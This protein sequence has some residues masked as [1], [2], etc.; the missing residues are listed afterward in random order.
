MKGISQDKAYSV[1]EI[2]TVVKEILE[3][4]LN[5]IWI[6]GEISNYSSPASGHIYFTLKDE[7]NQ[8]KTAF[9]GGRKKSFDLDLKDGKK[10]AVFGRLS[11]YGKRSE[12]QIIAEEIQVIGVGELLVE[13]EKLKKKL[14]SEGLFDEGKKVSIPEFPEKI[15]IITSR[16]GAAIRDILNIIS[17]RYPAVDI[18]IY[19]VMVQ[20]DAAPPQIIK[21]LKDM[22]TMGMD[23]IILTRGGGSMEDLWAFNDEKLAYQIAR[24]DTPVISAI[25]H[26][27]DFTI[28]DFVSDLRAPT[29]SAAAEL[30]VPDRQELMENIEAQ[31]NRIKRVI[32]G[33]V[34]ILDEK[35]ASIAGSY[36]FKIPFNMY[37]DYSRELDDLSENLEKS[38]DNVIKTNDDTLTVISDKLKISNPLNIL[39][40]GY[41]VVYDSATGRIIKDSA[42]AK[43]MIRIKLY[44]GGLEADVKSKY[45]SN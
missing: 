15:G 11:I 43:E 36:A 33:K 26:E 7:N 25:G 12:Y 2:T 8:I 30:V 1:S 14:S 10:V 35:L 41:S 20:G 9:F 38:L 40:K 31:K 24:T 32:S 4:N 18:L 13:F 27:I 5:T 28:A 21:A 19:P 34:D 29:P 22:D 37:N 6:Q 16:T 44:R 42:E 17:R 3:Q 45:N 39:K 23:V